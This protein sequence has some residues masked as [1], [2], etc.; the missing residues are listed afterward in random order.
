M[1]RST[2]IRRSS[3]RLIAAAAACLFV[4]G[5]SSGLDLKGDASANLKQALDHA[6]KGESL[7]KSGRF[8][9]AAEEYKK[10]IAAKGDLGAVWVNYGTCLIELGDYMPARDAFMRAAELLPA[11]PTPYENLG[12]LYHTRGYDEKALEYYKLSLEKDANWLPSLRG[13]VLA[14]KNLRT[15]DE[16]ARDRLDRAILIEKNPEFLNLM[17]VE[18]FR[19][20]AALKEKNGK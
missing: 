4:G 2:T 7:R 15:A 5:C 20:E 11:D 8:D 3:L 10:S 18:R 17:Q 19:I 16:G 6:S 9:A 1:S 14:V 13:S 12:T